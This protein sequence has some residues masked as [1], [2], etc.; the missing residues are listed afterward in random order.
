MKR[1]E[2]VYLKLWFEK[3]SFVMAM[4]VEPFP[5]SHLA[6]KLTKDCTFDYTLNTISCK[7]TQSAVKRLL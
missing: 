7:I 3:R 6:S 4:T 5:L 2:K 1:K